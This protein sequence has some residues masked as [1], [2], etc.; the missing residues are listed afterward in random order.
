MLAGIAKS[1]LL[2]SIA[3]LASLSNTVLGAGPRIPDTGGTPGVGSMVVFAH[4]GPI[5]G[6]L[7]GEVLPSL[8]LPLYLTINLR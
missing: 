5:R 2:V 7:T 6:V 3:L 8:L 4:P 1:D